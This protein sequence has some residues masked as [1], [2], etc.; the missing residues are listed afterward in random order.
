MTKI[1]WVR[2]IHLP[3]FNI[4]HFPCKYII[5]TKNKDQIV[6]QNSSVFAFRSLT[7]FGQIYRSSSGSHIQRYFNLELSDAVIA[8]DMFTIIKIIKIGL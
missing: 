5:F 7:C 8:V 4:I 3:F 6:T 2:D 1:Y